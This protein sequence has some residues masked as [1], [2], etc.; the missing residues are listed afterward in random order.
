MVAEGRIL[1]RPRIN[2]YGRS[3]PPSEGH[4][5]KVQNQPDRHRKDGDRSQPIPSPLQRV[6]LNWVDGDHE[7]VAEPRMAKE[8]SLP[9]RLSH[10][11]ALAPKEI[12]RL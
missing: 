7:V 6:G 9:I 5:P 11:C 10:L 8:R 2:R 12:N 1:Q 3:F 4:Q